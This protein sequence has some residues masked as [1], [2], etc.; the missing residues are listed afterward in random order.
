M[1]II[2][3]LKLSSE[4]VIS[5]IKNSFEKS[6]VKSQIK[7]ILTQ[8]DILT[9][10]RSIKHIKSRNQANQSAMSKQSTYSYSKEKL[11]HPLQPCIVVKQNESS[12]QLA[13]FVKVAMLQRDAL[14]KLGYNPF[15]FDS[16]E[17]K[18]Q[19]LK[20][21]LQFNEFELSDMNKLSIQLRNEY[22]KLRD[23]LK[24]S[25]TK[26]KDEIINMTVDESGFVIVD[27]MQSQEDRRA[28]KNIETV[29]VKKKIVIDRITQTDI[30][31]TMD[32]E[33]QVKIISQDIESE[34]SG[35]ESND[36]ARAT[37][38]VTINED[39]QSSNEDDDS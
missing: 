34:E 4:G 5:V 6:A 22:R 23:M 19:S 37:F 33:L 38:A 8:K 1:V 10:E 29:E 21:K 24:V 17:S 16:L 9:P 7:D 28:L 18:A 13:H 15:T 2:R 30:L 12:C 25:G 27:N 20:T 32:E 14:F 3:L 39:S 35:E 11:K 36:K 31:K 26:Y